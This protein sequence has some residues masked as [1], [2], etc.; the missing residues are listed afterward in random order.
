MVHHQTRSIP[1]P[2]ILHLF[3]QVLVDAVLLVGLKE[4]EES[5]LLTHGAAAHHHGQAFQQS[6]LTVKGLIRQVFRGTVSL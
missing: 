5:L 2:L 1:H 4:G 3:N 6:R